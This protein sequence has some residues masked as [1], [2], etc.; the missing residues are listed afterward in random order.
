MV[1][2][3]QQEELTTECLA[4]ECEEITAQVMSLNIDKGKL[5]ANI[6]F[7]KAKDELN[8]FIKQQRSSN[9]EIVAE[10]Q[11]IRYW[12]SWFKTN[13]KENLNQAT[14]RLADQLSTAQFKQKKAK[15]A[16]QEI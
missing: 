13:Q 15:Q 1:V 6:Q 10:L 11:E 14:Q 2:Q 7:E 3:K 5:V 12:I 9:N 4:K 16:W 8:L